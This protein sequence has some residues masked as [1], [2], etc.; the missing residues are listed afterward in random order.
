M[1][2]AH[3]HNNKRQVF[4]LFVGLQFSF[5]HPLTHSIP[6]CWQIEKLRTSGMTVGSYM[7]VLLL[8]RA[9]ERLVA[10]FVVMESRISADRRM[11]FS[12]VRPD[13]ER[14]TDDR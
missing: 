1:R 13:Q 8:V 12:Q 7:N 5:P 2:Q 10:L 9:D 3:T 11:A 14:S 4:F 6:V